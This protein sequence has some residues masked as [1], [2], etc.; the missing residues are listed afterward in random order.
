[1][2]PYIVT[3]KTLSPRVRQASE[4]MSHHFGRITGKVTERIAAISLIKSFAA[5]DRERQEFRADNEE[6]YSHIVRQSHI[7]HLMSA[8]S[9]TWI[10]LGVCLVW[11]WWLPGTDG[12]SR[13]HSREHHPFSGL[14]RD[15]VR[16]CQTAG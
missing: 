15:P 10:Q 12:Q 6:Y 2:P 11:L 9:D 14:C 7:G 8:L 5:E 13:Y 3:F 1:M 4:E 16:S